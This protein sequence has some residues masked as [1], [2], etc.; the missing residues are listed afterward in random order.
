M[1]RCVPS[2]PRHCRG[3]SG[4][5][6]RADRRV[7]RSTSG[8]AE[9]RR[10]PAGPAAHLGAADG[11][12]ARLR[13]LR[14]NRP[15]DAP[16]SSLIRR[17]RP[18]LAGIVQPGRAGAGPPVRAPGGDPP[19]GDGHVDPVRRGGQGL[20]LGGLSLA[21]VE[22][23]EIAPDNGLLV[24]SP[25]D[26]A[27]TKLKAILDRAGSRDYRGRPCSRAG[28]SSPT[29]SAGPRRYTGPFHRPAGAQGACLLR[30]ERPRFPARRNPRETHP[31]G[32]IGHWHPA[33]AAPPTRA[34][35]TTSSAGPATLGATDGPPDQLRPTRLP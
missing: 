2:S 31:R 14:R 28:W 11:D 35:S 10:P 5:A 33:D 18:L 32:S 27:A 3:A 30:G 8:R 21:A 23:P 26:L 13:P 15:R 16:R 4:D 34:C 19:V 17:P 1:T 25:P 9:D 6:L 7:R 12:P 29:S 20:F 24:A 22:R